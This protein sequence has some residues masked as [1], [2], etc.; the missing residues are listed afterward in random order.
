MGFKH[1]GAAVSVLSFSSLPKG[2]VELLPAVRECP[3]LAPAGEGLSFW[4]AGQS[5]RLSATELSQLDW[6]GVPGE[7]LR[8]VGSLVTPDFSLT[9]ETRA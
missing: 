4:P 8:E 5:R 2:P 1:I 6:V 9:G 3:S 7:G